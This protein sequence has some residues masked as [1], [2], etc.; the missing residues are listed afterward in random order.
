MWI[1]KE[2]CQACRLS[3]AVGDTLAVARMKANARIDLDAN[4]FALVLDDIR[5]PGN[6]GTIIRTADWYGINKIIASEETVDFYSNKVITSTMGSFT[7]VK[8]FY[9]N[10]EEFL[11]GTKHKVM[12]A[13]LN[14]EDVHHRRDTARVPRSLEK[15]A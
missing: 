11:K 9:A 13:F 10:L 4:E 7:R 14:G 6:L 3:L 2:G 12:G 1:V 5:D 8:I 15:S